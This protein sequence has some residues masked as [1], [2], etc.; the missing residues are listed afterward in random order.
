[1]DFLRLEDCKQ[2]LLNC[3]KFE[4]MSV[5]F[6]VKVIGI[7][8]ALMAQTVDRAVF[9]SRPESAFRCVIGQKDSF[10]RCLG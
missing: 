7:F 8:S 9:Y 10:I 4:F 1:L 5:D 2:A 6:E 3:E